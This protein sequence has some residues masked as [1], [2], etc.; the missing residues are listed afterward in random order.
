[1]FSW[2][3]MWKLFC[4]SWRLYVKHF[5]FS[6]IYAVKHFCFSWFSVI[7]SLFLCYTNNQKLPA[8]CLPIEKGVY[9]YHGISKKNIWQASEMETII[10]RFLRHFAGALQIYIYFL[11]R[12]L[13]FIMPYIWHLIL[14][15][16]GPYTLLPFS[17]LKVRTRK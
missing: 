15:F 11:L 12:S 16:H 1:M 4:F 3:Y 13:P 7:I 9:D 5:S 17:F 6:W 14:P 2:R 10:R 8:Q